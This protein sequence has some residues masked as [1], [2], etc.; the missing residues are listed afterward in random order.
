MNIALFTALVTVTTVIFEWLIMIYRKK[1]E[2][3]AKHEQKRINAHY[4]NKQ[5]TREV[6]TDYLNVYILIG[7][8]IAVF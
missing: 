2:D 4:P 6:K 7:M 1:A 8:C 3:E 5:L